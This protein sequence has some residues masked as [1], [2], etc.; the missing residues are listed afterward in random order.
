MR[1][2][3]PLLLLAALAGCAFEAP[4]PDWSAP[5]AP[6]LP[7]SVQDVIKLLRAG[8]SETAI[9]VTVREEGIESRPTMAQIAELR[10][11]GASEGFIA[12]LLAAAVP[13]PLEPA[14]APQLHSWPYFHP[15]P[16][17]WPFP[18]WV[19]QEG[20]WRILAWPRPAEP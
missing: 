7:L 19:W 1:M 18:C 8:I 17:L 2:S 15:F 13:Y 20:K 12:G 10:E 9:F 16:G 4:Y 14:D 11:V 3:R 6:P 5:P